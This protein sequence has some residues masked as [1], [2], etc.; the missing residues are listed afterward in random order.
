MQMLSVG[1]TSNMLDNLKD[2]R[3]VLASNSPRRKDLLAGLGLD[4]IVR[5]PDHVDESFPVGM[6]VSEIAV[7]IARK[8]AEASVSRS[9]PGDLVITADTVVE[10]QGQILG[11][12][13]DRADAIRMLE[14]LSGKYHRVYTGVC[15]VSE[16]F[17]SSFTSCTTVCFSELEAEEITHYVEVFK[18][19]D[20]AGAYGIQEWIGYVGVERM[21]GSYY[22]V[23]GLP[24]HQL[25]LAL[26]HV[27]A[28]NREV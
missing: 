2:Y 16:G 4:F 6:D 26:K 11:K 7:Y 17:R 22:N 3:L 21:E 10:V 28:L 24:I 27:P 23:M 20:K 15:L 12:P 13:A 8:K 9:E 5:T 19:Y 1:K 14:N 18:P 25:Y